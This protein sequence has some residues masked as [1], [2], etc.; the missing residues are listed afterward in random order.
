[1][2]DINNPM[3][4]FHQWAGVP[5]AA[6]KNTHKSLFRRLR[7]SENQCHSANKSYSAFRSIL[8]R[9]YLTS[10]VARSKNGHF[11]D[12]QQG[13]FE[14]GEIMQTIVFVDIDSTLV[15]NHFSRKVIGT[16]LREIA[17]ATGKTLP[18][19]GKEM[20]IENSHRQKNDPD[21]VLTMDWDDIVRTLA[22]RYQVTPSQ[23]LIA[24]WEESALAEDVEILDESPTVMR[25]LKADHRQLVIAT[26]G[27]MK[28]QLPV[29]RAAGLET[30]FD[31]ILTPDKTG[32]LK[33]TPAYFDS[34]LTR[35]PDACFIQVGDH[36]VDDLICAK[37]NGFYSIL[38]APIAALTDL[39]PFERAAKLPEFA[40]HISTYPTE[41]SDILPDAVAVS[42]AELPT[43]IPVLEARYHTNGRR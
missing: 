41:G 24:L 5:H 33:T 9:E 15:E 35:Y 17:D 27:L 4:H 2:L 26:K 18:E 23:S 39:D 28:Y 42:L 8:I 40:A 16:V 37:R 6:A 21:N 38:R 20:G 3:R 29:L 36:Y 11:D 43:I 22:A 34:Y 12:N 7:H 13:N 31:D 14:T 25:Q 1:M 30:L 19:L 32:Y 10:Q